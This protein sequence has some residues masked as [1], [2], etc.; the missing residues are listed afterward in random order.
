MVPMTV[1]SSSP[2]GITLPVRVVVVPSVEIISFGLALGPGSIW[3][4]T[5][6]V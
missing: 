1:K 4:V 2:V 3:P 6:T 5:I